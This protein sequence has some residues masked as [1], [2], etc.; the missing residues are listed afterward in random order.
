M[1]WRRSRQPVARWLPLGRRL[2]TTKNNN[3][4]DD[5]DDDDDVNPLGVVPHHTTCNLYS[6]IMSEDPETL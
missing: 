3:N 1:S 6:T 5:V 4:D 2:T